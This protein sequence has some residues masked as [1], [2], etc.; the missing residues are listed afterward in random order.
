ME[1][2][3]VVKPRAFDPDGHPT[4]GTSAIHKPQDVCDILESIAPNVSELQLFGDDAGGILSS[5]KSHS[6]FR[7]HY[8][9]SFR[10]CFTSRFR[11][12]ANVFVPHISLFAPPEPLEFGVGRA[13]NVILVRSTLISTVRSD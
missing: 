11:L 8:H 3:A 13:S 10:S 2:S 6:V 9:L 12:G 5:R 1:I 4:M 7:L